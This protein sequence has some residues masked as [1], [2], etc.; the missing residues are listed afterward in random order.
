[1][2]EHNYS[3]AAISRAIG[4]FAHSYNIQQFNSI[5]TVQSYLTCKTTPLRYAI[6]AY[7]RGTVLRE[8]VTHFGI[9][10][11]HVSNHTWLTTFFK[12]LKEKS[13]RDQ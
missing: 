13:N 7:R 4:L 5:H 11:N 8:Y 1:M 12:I 2:N 3:I 6:Q 9:Q 10:P